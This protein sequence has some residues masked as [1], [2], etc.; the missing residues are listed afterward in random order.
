[1]D[2]NGVASPKEKPG[3]RILVN[4]SDRDATL[5]GHKG[6]GYQVQLAE[7]RG[8]SNEVQLIL[9]VEPQGAVESDSKAP[10]IDGGSAAQVVAI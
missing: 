1:M 9:R 10:A 7:T 3:G 6:T 4:P 5:D 2:S 8:E